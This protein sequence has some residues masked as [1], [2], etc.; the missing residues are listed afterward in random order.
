MDALT[1]SNLEDSLRPEEKSEETSEKD[2]DK[3]N[4]TTCDIIRCCLTKTLSIMCYMRLS[5][6]RFGRSSREV[7][8]KE[9]QI[10]I[11]SEEEAL[12]L[13]IEERASIVNT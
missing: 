13:P 5:Q 1:A 4:K 10:S 7:S 3:M 12:S 2:W 8:E 9:H 11:A 6:G